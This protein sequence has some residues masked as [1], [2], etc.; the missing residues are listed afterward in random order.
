MSGKIT[1][2][3]STATLLKVLGALRD[4]EDVLARRINKIHGKLQTTGDKNCVWLDFGELTMHIYIYILTMYLRENISFG[5]SYRSR[6]IK[7][8]PPIAIIRLLYV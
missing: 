2:S 6:S 7:D 1:L 4:E 5:I 8:A 3:D